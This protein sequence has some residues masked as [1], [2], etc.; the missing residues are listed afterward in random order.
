MSS[1]YEA[2]SSDDSYESSNYVTSYKHGQRFT[3]EEDNL[4]R[5]LA[6]DKRNM[7]WKEIASHLPGR[8]ACQCR[9]R[10]NQYLFKKVVNDPWTL[11]EDNIIVEKYQMYGPHWVKISEFL[12]GRSGNNVKNRWHCALTKYHGISY[13]NTKQQRRPRNLKWK[14]ETVSTNDI[15]PASLQSVKLD[16]SSNDTKTSKKANTEFR[17]PKTQDEIQDLSFIENNQTLLDTLF[18]KVDGLDEFSDLKF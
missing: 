15:K 17:S 4:L 8:T 1:S 3:K 13:T 10:F 11:E 7:S 18:G 16:T 2:S 6:K 5:E 12:P 14:S 9:D